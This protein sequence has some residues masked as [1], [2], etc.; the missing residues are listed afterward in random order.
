MDVEIK[1]IEPMKVA[2]IR[3][4]GP[5]DQCKST[6]EKL[7]AELG[8]KGVFGP[9][10]KM[11][12]LCHDDPDNTAPEKIRYDACATV[13]ES[14]TPEG[15]VQVQTIPGGQYAT[16]IHKGPYENLKD[17]WNKMYRQ[18]IPA[19]NRQP[20][21]APCFEIYLNCPET[22]PPEEL[23]TAMYVPLAPQV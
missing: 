23:L 7:G 20:L 15:E 16:A 19:S 11:I 6:W 8:P 10:T 22:S 13:D 5:Y 9:E 12:G 21:E 3:H 1:T 4:T 2:Y 14:F 18:L 17:S